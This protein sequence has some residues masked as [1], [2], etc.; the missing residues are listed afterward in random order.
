MTEHASTA[1]TNPESNLDAIIDPEAVVNDPAQYQFP[2]SFAQQRLWFLDQLE[3]PSAVYNVKL[4]VRLVGELDF[5]IL[6]QAIDRLVDRHESLRTTIVMRQ[7]EP[8]Q[9]VNA[10]LCVPLQIIDMQADDEVA[11]RDKAAELAGESFNLAQGPLFR[12]FVIRAAPDNQLL[13]LVTHHVISDAWSSSV[14]F[15][16]LAAIYA[17]LV[18][19]QTPVLAELRVQYADYA[20]WQREWLEGAELDRQAAYWKNKLLAAPHVLALPTDRPRP[21]RQTYNGSR[22]SLVLTRE[23]TAALKALAAEQSCTLFMVM[24][25]AFNVLLGRYAGQ[26]DVLIG[27]PIA[28]RRRTELEG[29]VGLFVNTLVFRNDLSGNPSFRSLLS[30][31]RGTAL[32]AF[33]HQELPF[34]KLVEI[35]LDEHHLEQW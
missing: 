17:A 18:L 29:L 16:D 28:G 13:L 23:L 20:V 7:G 21:P 33:G 19:G 4:P 2:V 10:S 6:Q 27:S 3:G 12:S 8:V 24:L 25:A 32:E 31:V 11:I 30:R 35:L 1:H 9:V 26:D 22:H 14:L 5:D 34:E 15:R